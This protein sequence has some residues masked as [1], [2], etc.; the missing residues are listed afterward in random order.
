MKRVKNEKCR[1]TDLYINQRC[2]VLEINIF[3]KQLKLRL[4]E[5]G[6]VPNVIIKMKKKA[7][8][9]KSYSN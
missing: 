4:L 3:D 7:P 6:L 2:K 1:L 9:R 5:M 8:F